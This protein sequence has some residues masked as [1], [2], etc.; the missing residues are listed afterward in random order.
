MK[1]RITMKDPDTLDDA[2]REAAEN[3]VE[4]LGLSPEEAE[5]VVDTRIAQAQ[6]VCRRWFEYGEYLRV[7]VD[8]EAGTAIVVPVSG[9]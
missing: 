1:L 7:D 3:S 8:T 6:K 9:Q 2:I 5:A 4:P